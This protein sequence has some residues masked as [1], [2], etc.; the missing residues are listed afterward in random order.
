L[1]YLAPATTALLVAA[2]IVPQARAQA[3]PTAPYLP[4]ELAQQAANAALGKCAADGYNVSVAIVDRSGVTKVLIKADG[5]GPHTINSSTGKAF[6]SASMG[7]ATAE[8]AE[9]IASKPAL[10]GLRDMD[11]RLVIL[12]GGL[13]VRIGGALGSPG[14]ERSCGGS[15]SGGPQA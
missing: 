5:A 3:L 1:T 11:D 6:T 4:L 13:P 12:G 10:A 15:T 8:F 9:L 2:L 14:G 7:R